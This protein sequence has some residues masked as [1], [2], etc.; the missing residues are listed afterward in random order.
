MTADWQVDAP[1]GGIGVAI[2]HRIVEAQNTV[3]LKLGRKPPM[4]KVGFGHKKQAAGVLVD[5]VDDA[6]P[7]NPSNAGQ[8]VATVVKQGIDQCALPM[9][10]GGVHHHT[11]GLVDHQQHIVLIEDVQIDA[12][13]LDLRGQRLGKEQSDHIPCCTGVFLLGGRSLCK[14]RPAP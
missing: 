11:L 1:L 7:H 2:D 5:A 3:G 8:T 13:G 12:F 6:R 10:G 9:S 4:G 14:H